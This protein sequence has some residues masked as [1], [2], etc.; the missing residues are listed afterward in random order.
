MSPLTKF[1]IIF[2]IY[3]YW[4]RDLII[5]K[6]KLDHS[7]ENLLKLSDFLLDYDNRKD[8]ESWDF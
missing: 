3:K 6:I 4:L 2:L 1:K 8:G 7:Y 5:D